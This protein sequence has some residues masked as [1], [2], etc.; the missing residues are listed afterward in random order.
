MNSIS[1]RIDSEFDFE[2]VIRKLNDLGIPFTSKIIGDV[3][4]PSLVNQQGFAIITVSEEYS[5]PMQTVLTELLRDNSMAATNNT[6]LPKQKKYNVKRLFW[7]GYTVIITI[8]FLRGWYLDELAESGKNT[9]SAWSVDGASWVTKRRD[10]G[11]MMSLLI[12]ANYDRNFELMS[13]YSREGVRV[14]EAWDRNE[15]GYTEH[16]VRFNLKGQIAAE[17]FDRNADGCIEAS[18]IVLDNGQKIE[19][20]DSNN[21]G[22]FELVTEKD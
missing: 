4:F 12:D 11:K 18:T 6:A 22:S 5:I 16:V 15:D 10:N 20:Y 21:D 13:S 9:T 8:L 14:M 2:I 3:S 17:D 19:L 1:H 7:I